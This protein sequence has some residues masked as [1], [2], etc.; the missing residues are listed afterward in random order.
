MTDQIPISLYPAEQAA[1][2]S[3]AASGLREQVANFPKLSTEGL[4][5]AHATAINSALSA[6]RTLLSETARTH[7]VGSN[8]ASALGQTD[9]D[10]GQLYGSVPDAQRTTSI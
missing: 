4:L 6:A 3:S 9:Q 8:G 1:T 7:D 10:N 5:P 2:H